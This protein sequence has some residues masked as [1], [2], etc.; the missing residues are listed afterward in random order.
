MRPLRQSMSGLGLLAPALLWT[1]LFFLLP[2][3]VMAV[4]SLGQK[5]GGRLLPGWTLANYARLIIRF[6]HPA[7]MT[8]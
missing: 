7:M 6:T 2:L 1:T 4:Q 8:L 5:V 3:G